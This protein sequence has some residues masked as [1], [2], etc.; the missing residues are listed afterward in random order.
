MAL[1]IFF[2]PELMLLISTFILLIVNGK[3][4]NLLGKIIKDEDYV[5]Y[6]EDIHAELPVIRSTI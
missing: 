3:F 5:T 2:T 1:Y 6:D 4:A